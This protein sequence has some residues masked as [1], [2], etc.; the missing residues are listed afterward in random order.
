M[1]K[2]IRLTNID[3]LQFFKILKIKSGLT[4]KDLSELCKI[5]DKTLQ[6]WARAKYTPLL[7]TIQFLSNKFK[8]KIPDNF[9]ILDAHWHLTRELCQQGAKARQEKHGILGDIESRRLGGMISQKRRKENPEKYHNLG[10]NVEKRVEPLTKSLALAE[11]CGIL[12]G[13]GGIT[14]SQVRVTLHKKDDAAYANFVSQLMDQVLKEKPSEFK[15]ENT[16]NLTLSSIAFVRELE[17]IGLKRGNKVV[18]QVGVPIWILKNKRYASVCLRGLVDTDGGVYFH[19]HITKGKKYV[20]FG[21]CFT[22]S[23]RPLLRAV[24][25]TLLQNSFNPKIANGRQVFLYNFNE[26][27]K[28]FEVIGSNNPKHLNRLKSYLRIYKK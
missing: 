16:I 15:R 25:D 14:D 21:L 8:I 5:S 3:Q 10:C 9:E 6:D 11:L 19:H 18:N 13:D 27:K 4:W 24:F 1:V 23:S 20:H 28:Y 22:N 7:K 17:K 12:L 26:V 2:R